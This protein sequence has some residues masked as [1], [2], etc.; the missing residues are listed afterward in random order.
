M[1][2]RHLHTWGHLGFLLLSSR[3]FIVLPFTSRSV[4]NF[5]FSFCKETIF[6][7]PVS[8]FFFFFFGLWM[9]SCS[10]T[11]CRKNYLLFMVLPLLLCHESIDYNYRGLF[12]NSIYGLSILFHW[13][14][15]SIFSPIP[16]CLDYFTFIIGL[17]VKKYQ[18][19]NFILLQYC[20][21]YS[22]YFAS[23]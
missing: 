19:S 18:S 14:N 10:N 8:R 1:S 4:I 17:K 13:P 21:G 11:I 23:S 7:M 12:L 9:S 22:R 6:V 5:E 3:S 2:K 15:L 16:H 20:V